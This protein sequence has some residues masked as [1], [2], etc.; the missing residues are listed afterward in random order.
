M[1][2]GRPGATDR[3]VDQVVG[4]AEG[5]RRRVRKKMENNK[6]GT[7]HKRKYRRRKKE[8]RRRKEGTWVVLDKSNKRR[9][10]EW[11]EIRRENV[12]DK[13]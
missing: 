10:T 6:N 13:S 8:A 7:D 11:T 4:V 1:E 12:Q 3:E 2:D 5:L 9:R